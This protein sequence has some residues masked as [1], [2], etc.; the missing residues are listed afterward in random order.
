MSRRVPTRRGA[1]DGGPRQRP[2]KVHVDK[3][4]DIPR[5]HA[6]PRRCGIQDRIA[7]IGIESSERL[8]RVHWV[9]ERTMAWFTEIDTG[10]ECNDGRLSH[11]ADK[12]GVPDLR[13]GRTLQSYAPM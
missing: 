12:S 3:A 9:V 6:Y 4:Y 1:P 10:G 11:P 5:Y 13:S 2:D 7:R 8:G